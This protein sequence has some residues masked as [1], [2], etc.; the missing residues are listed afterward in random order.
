[1][2]NELLPQAPSPGKLEESIESMHHQTAAWHAKIAFWKDELLFFRKLIGDT[3]FEK[4]D[5][6]ERRMLSDSLEGLA[7]SELALLEDDVTS[8]DNQL[9]H[10]IG[11]EADTGSAR[12]S[13]ALLS[14][15][16]AE[17]ERRLRALRTFVLDIGVMTEKN[18]F[19]G[20]E[21][22]DTIR[23][24]RAVRKYTDEAVPAITIHEMLEAAAMAPS[25]MNMQPWKFFV[26]TNSKKIRHFSAEITNTAEAAYPEMA[27][28]MS[29]EPDPIFHDAPVVVLITAPKTNEWARIDVGCCAQN[30]MLAA[31]SLGYASCP[32]GLATL[33]NKS[34]A[35]D[36][37]GIPE[38]EDVIL[39]VTIGRAAETPAAPDRKTGSIRFVV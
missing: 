19:N 22:L 26:L 31:A 14:R 15:K 1:M 33:I 34:S 4:V 21:T 3:L 23:R 11:N 37:L 10:G 27:K 2:K 25:A 8:H 7:G 5:E 35:F 36:E 28:L 30:L 32:V 16:V 9:I 24:R 18:F 13:H 29:S 17:I 39:G 38:H 12:Q 6:H 20:N